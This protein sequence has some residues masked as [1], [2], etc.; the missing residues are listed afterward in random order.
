MEA[1]EEC[2]QFDRCSCNVCPQEMAGRRLSD[3]LSVYS[4]RGMEVE[5]SVEAQENGVSG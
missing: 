4:K 5:M 1:H 2:P 3:R